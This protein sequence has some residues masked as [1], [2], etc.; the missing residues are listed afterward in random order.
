MPAPGT[1]TRWHAPSGPGVRLDGGYDQG[2]TVPGAFDSLV[3]K[4]IVTGRDRDAGAGALPP[5]ARASSSSRACR[6]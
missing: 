4:L 2:E 1:L 5:R 3:A 6:R